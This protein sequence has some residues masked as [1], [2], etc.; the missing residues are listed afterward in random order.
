MGRDLNLL[1]LRLI[2]FQW[3]SEY[4]PEKT[5]YPLRRQYCEQRLRLRFVQSKTLV[6]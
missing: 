4:S 6:L 3:D 2:L 1:P 5:S